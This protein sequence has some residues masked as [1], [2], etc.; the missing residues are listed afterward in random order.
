MNN[1]EKIYIKTATNKKDYEQLALI[2]SEIWH[3]H[4]TPII[5]N[6]QV[7]YM[8]T[9]FQTASKIEDAVN[10]DKTIYYMPYYNQKLAGYSAIKKIDNSFFLSKLYVHSNFRGHGI[11]RKLLSTIEEYALSQQVNTIFLT[12][13]KNNN[14][15]ISIYKHLGFVITDK[16]IT[17]IGGGY[18]MDDYKMTLSI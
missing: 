11:A 7:A 2:A 5:G 12:V 16:L 14:Q 15:S 13:N 8:L 6:K 9:Q 10:Q 3:E 18:V 1:I 4:Y 17:D